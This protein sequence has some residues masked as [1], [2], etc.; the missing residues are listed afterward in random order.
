MQKQQNISMGVLRPAV[1]LHRP[2]APAVQHLR[3]ELPGNGHGPVGTATVHHNQFIT[4]GQGDAPEGRREM[5][6]LIE[7]R[8]NHGDAGGGRR[9]DPGASAGHY[10]RCPAAAMTP[11]QYGAENARRSDT[12]GDSVCPRWRMM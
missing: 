10:V 11:D 6:L 9:C 5:V 7:G 12:D 1:H 4:R 3:G 8:H 2:P